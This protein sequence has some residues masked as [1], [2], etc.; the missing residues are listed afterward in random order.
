M[1]QALTDSLDRSE[2]P[3]LDEVVYSDGVLNVIFVDGKTFV[4]NKQTPN[5]QIWLSSPL[6]GP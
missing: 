2:H 5:Q 1:L 4:V 6:S 3:A